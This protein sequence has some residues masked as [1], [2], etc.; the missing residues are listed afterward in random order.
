MAAPLELLLDGF[1][2]DE[3][4]TIVPGTGFTAARVRVGTRLLPKPKSGR[5][6][7]LTSRTGRTARIL[8]KPRLAGFDPCPAI[9][10]DDVPYA[11]GW[12]AIPV[13]DWLIPFLLA[14]PCLA[15]G[16]I[17]GGF[18]GAAAAFTMLIARSRLPRGARI[19]LSILAS[20]CAFALTL[21]VTSAFRSAIGAGR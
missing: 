21:L 4:P 14:A 2:V 5:P 10:V 7:A 9:L 18:G 3:R 20:L 15:G 16:A 12:P 17:G 13:V 19:P 8:L 6:Y 1:D 11:A